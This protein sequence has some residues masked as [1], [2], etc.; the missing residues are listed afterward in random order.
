MRLTA[1][2]TGNNINA[3]VDFHILCA[4][5]R[6]IGTHDPLSESNLRGICKRREEFESLLR[7]AQ[8]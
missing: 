7:Q 5:A 8:N 2:P 3:L 1:H 6:H 4:F